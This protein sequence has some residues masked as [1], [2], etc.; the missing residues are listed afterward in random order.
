MCLHR[1]CKNDAVLAWSG[2]V[3]LMNWSGRKLFGERMW[4]SLIPVGSHM[5]SVFLLL[6]SFGLC[7][8]LGRPKHWCCICSLCHWKNAYGLGGLFRGTFHFIK[9]VDKGCHLLKAWRQDPESAMY[10]PIWSTESCRNQS[11]HCPRTWEKVRKMLPDCQGSPHGWNLRKKNSSTNL[12]NPSPPHS[13]ASQ[14]ALAVK[15]P[16]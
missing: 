4:I 1:E 15:N 8:T 16:P 11:I 10:S 13:G 6:A 2:G 3:P 12:I 5:L 14:V 9:L 7:G